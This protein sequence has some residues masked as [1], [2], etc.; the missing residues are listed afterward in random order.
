MAAQ[1]VEI[2]QVD[3]ELL[4]LSGMESCLDSPDGITG[5]VGGVLGQ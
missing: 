1:E 5:P 2:V 3:D 4:D